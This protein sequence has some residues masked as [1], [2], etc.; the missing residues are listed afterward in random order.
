MGERSYWQNNRP[1]AQYFT[2]YIV[3]E[4]KFYADV[5]DGRRPSARD[6]LSGAPGLGSLSGSGLEI[7]DGQRLSSRAGTAPSSPVGRSSSSP[8]LL[9]G[10]TSSRL[11]L[12]CSSADPAATPRSLFWTTERP[13]PQMRPSTG[14]PVPVVTPPRMPPKGFGARAPRR[15]SAA[16]SGEF[17]YFGA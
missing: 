10:E 2:Q 14:G 15:G 1:F 3:K 9:G 5:L 6:R 7:I 12:T 8:G 16:D 17:Y 13:V 11:G 4:Q